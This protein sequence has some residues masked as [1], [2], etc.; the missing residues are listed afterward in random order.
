MAE[1]TAV[2]KAKKTKKLGKGIEGN[3]LTITEAVTG[4][5][6][7]FDAASLPKEIQAKLMPYGL[8]QKLGDAAA[9][10]SG[11]VAIDAIN[12]V[13]EGLMKSDWTVRAPAAE[14]IDKKGVLEKF[15]ALD[16]KTKAMLAGNEKTKTLLEALGVKF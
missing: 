3:L 1:E 13:W 9:G 2:A 15:N 7:K 4:T 5:V 16:A 11:Q 12:K 10:K 8:S 14:K 6:L